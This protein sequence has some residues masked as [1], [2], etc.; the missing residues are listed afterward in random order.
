M[1]LNISQLLLRR[2]WTLSCKVTSA[3]TLSLPLETDRCETGLPC[4]SKNLRS[5]SPSTSIPPSIGK[6]LHAD[7]KFKER[8]GKTHMD[9]PVSARKSQS[10]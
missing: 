8:E 3:Q 1:Y 2:A 7:V 10:S 4:F 9:P 6:F 5:L